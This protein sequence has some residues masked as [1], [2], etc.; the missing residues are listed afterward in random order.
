MSEREFWRV[1]TH[2]CDGS[3]TGWLPGSAGGTV[4]FVVR[5]DCPADARAA[6]VGESGALVVRLDDGRV[7]SFRSW[8]VS[9]VTR[10]RSVPITLYHMA[11][12][13]RRVVS[14]QLAQAAR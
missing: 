3:L 11:H 5:A 8:R 14:V 7:G 2:V 4:A 10:A 13:A 6:L 9:S 12:G 1:V